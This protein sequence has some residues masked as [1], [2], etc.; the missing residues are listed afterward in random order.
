LEPRDVLE[1]ARSAAL[2]DEERA[3]WIGR[4]AHSKQL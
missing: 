4:A 1:A 2:H 3:P